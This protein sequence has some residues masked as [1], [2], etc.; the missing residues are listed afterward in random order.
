MLICDIN[1][2]L[3]AEMWA[4]P[5][6]NLRREVF[7]DRLAEEG[8]EYAD[9]AEF[10][11]LQCEISRYDPNYY[12]SFGNRRICEKSA[13][14]KIARSTQLLHKA[15]QYLLA[16]YY[17]RPKQPGSLV[18]FDIEFRRGFV[19]LLEWRSDEFVP[20]RPEDLQCARL[21]RITNPLC[22]LSIGNKQ[23]LLRYMRGHD[24][25]SWTSPNARPGWA[26]YRAFEIA[27]YIYD[28]VQ[29]KGKDDTILE[30]FPQQRSCA[31]RTQQ[32]ARDAYYDA[33]TELAFD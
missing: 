31:F 12:L 10:I 4:H 15:C 33:C 19:S 7:A 13:D 11:Y 24:Y 2:A 28:R 23:P 1:P 8:E 32:Q 22:R 26:G 18:S 6:D 27:P 30:T 16:P 21:V 9:L 5:E 17:Q 14:P 29:T 25:Y 20:S 3:W